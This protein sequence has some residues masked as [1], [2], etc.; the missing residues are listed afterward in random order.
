MDFLT[1]QLLVVRSST[2]LR[3]LQTERAAL[4]FGEEVVPEGR[5]GEALPGSPSLG[6]LVEYLGESEQIEDPSVRNL[7]PQGNVEPKSQQYVE[8]KA[9]SYLGKKV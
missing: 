6:K 9:K 8:D 1:I 5:L 4:L 7:K 3:L 2:R